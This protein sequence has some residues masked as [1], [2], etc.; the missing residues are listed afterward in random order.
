[1]STKTLT[2]I[3]RTLKDFYRD[4]R[5]IGPDPVLDRYQSQNLDDYI[6]FCCKN[7]HLIEAYT[8]SLQYAEDLIILSVKTDK[9]INN[10]DAPKIISILGGS[11]II[12]DAYKSLFFRIN[13]IRNDL[14]HKMLKDPS[15]VKEISQINS[16]RH[17]LDLLELIKKTDDFYLQFVKGEIKRLNEF[18]RATLSK[19]QAERGIAFAGIVAKQ[20]S[21]EV[22]IPIGNLNRESW[23]KKYK[24]EFHKIFQ[25]KHL[26]LIGRELGSKL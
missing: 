16:K 1:M 6:K 12:T 2:S 17:T 3:T 14:V 21:Q 15:I 9:Y 19:L 13:D 7:S 11:N 5:F 18:P 10:T 20:A 26:Q 22:N 23:E 8:L 25:K 4:N 24:E